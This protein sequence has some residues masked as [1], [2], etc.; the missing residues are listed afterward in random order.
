MEARIARLESDVGHVRSSISEL[1]VKV[2]K[3]RDELTAK[4]DRVN[5]QLT[6]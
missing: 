6:E 4:I 5:V 2:D 1:N 3:V